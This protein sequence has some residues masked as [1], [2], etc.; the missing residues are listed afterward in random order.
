MANLSF[1]EAA[2]L[3]RRAGLG[4]TSDEIDDLVSRGRE[5]AVDFLLNYTQIDNKAMDDLLLQSY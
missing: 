5:G 4:G 2:H 1:D 3:I